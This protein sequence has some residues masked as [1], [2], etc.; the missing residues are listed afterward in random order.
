MKSLQRPFLVG[1]VAA[2]S[3]LLAQLPFAGGA[4]AHPVRSRGFRT[5]YARISNDNCPCQTVWGGPAVS[6]AAI[7]R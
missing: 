1:P 3:L 4:A 5:D 6:L 2:I 7:L